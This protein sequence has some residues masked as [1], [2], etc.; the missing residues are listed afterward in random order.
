ML[1][2]MIHVFL[3]QVNTTHIEYKLNIQWVVKAEIDNFSENLY[4][5][6]GEQHSESSVYV[7]KNCLM[8]I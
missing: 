2:E 6:Q 5:W 4:Q 3:L 7:K 1:T 8:L